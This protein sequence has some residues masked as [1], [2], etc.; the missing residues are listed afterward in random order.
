MATATTKPA[1][2]PAKAKQVFLQKLEKRRR[3]QKEADALLLEA[4]EQAKIAR[5]GGIKIR[6]L[7]RDAGVSHVAVGWWIKKA[8]GTA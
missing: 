3:L 1:A 4:A 8:E 5:D 7:A 6:E 2:S